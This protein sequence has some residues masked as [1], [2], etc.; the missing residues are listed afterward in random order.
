MGSIMA[1][2]RKVDCILRWC[3]KGLKPAKTVAKQEE[4][5]VSSK[6]HEGKQQQRLMEM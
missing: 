4:S 2:M 6:V 3:R 1:E 5:G